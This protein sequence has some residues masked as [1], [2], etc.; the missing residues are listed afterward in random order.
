MRRKR[1]NIM[2]VAAI[3]I[4]MMPYYAMAV[5]TITG[6]IVGFNSI[7]HGKEAPADYNDPHIRLEPDFVLLTSDGGH[8]LLPN[9]PKH[10]KARN[11]Y[12]EVKVIG[13]I[14]EKYRSMEVDELQIQA[15]KGFSTIWS[16]KL[17]EEEVDGRYDN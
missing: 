14:V 11:I 6:K 7:I 10:I 1:I 13:D 12:R 3:I 17:A 2:L 5:E 9:V 8:Y 15:E 16:R 4:P